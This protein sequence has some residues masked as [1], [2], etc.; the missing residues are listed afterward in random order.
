MN[1]Q[2]FHLIKSMTPTVI[3][4]HQRSLNFYFNPN[5]RSYGQ[6]FVLVFVHFSPF[7]KKTIHRIK[8]KRTKHHN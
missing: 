4:G 5:L 7:I 1:T 2:I 8:T 6:Q 3:E